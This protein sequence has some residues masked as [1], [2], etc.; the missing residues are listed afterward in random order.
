MLTDRF[1]GEHTTGR[2]EAIAAFEDAVAA[3]AAHRPVGDALK[4]ALAADPNMIAAHALTGF[5]SL[6][7]GRTETCAMAAET[8]QT[9]KRAIAVTAHLT[10]SEKALADSLDK[11]VNGYF[12]LAAERL[13]AHLEK[14]PEDFLAAKIAHALRFMLGDR[15]GMLRLT[16]D[17]VKRAP[18]SGAGYGFLLGCHAFGLEE[19]GAYREAEAVGRAAVKKEPAD[20][21]GL[22]AVSHV[23]EMTG[24]IDEGRDWLNASRPTWS[25][26]NNFSFHMAWHLALFHLEMGDHETVLS[27][28]D[29]EIRPQQTDD[30]RDMS[31]AVSMLWRLEQE[32]VDVGDR[33]QPL[34]EIAY[35]R[36]KDTAY[37]FG[38]LHYLLALIA[39]G[40][41]RA[42]EEL[43]EA[44]REQK[45]G[46]SDQSRVTRYIGVRV[47]EALIQMPGHCAK[48][49]ICL[50]EM[51]KRLPV[52]G[53]SYAQRDVFVRALMAVAMRSRDYPSLRAIVALRH[54]LR[55]EDR[56]D[57]AVIA[58]MADRSAPRNMP[59]R[60]H[61]DHI[62]LVRLI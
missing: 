25:R 27:L 43:I 1:Y 59:I 6:L 45:I 21:W 39:S 12:R 30:F 23:Y 51:A 37:V 62:A 44:L 54:E 8:A 2:P 52:I 48:S 28:Y 13:E 55:H 50:A 31:N 10:P 56:F 42:A 4:R 3:V 24:R 19:T 58:R 17:L 5:G 61:D 46:N 40:D 18:Q 57:K 34:Y 29:D 20:S 35:R 32:G 22:H 11:G 14:A 16:A 53:G 60:H 49:E 36:R 38:S 41:L 15:E 33:W 26:C 9:L 47:A 7:L